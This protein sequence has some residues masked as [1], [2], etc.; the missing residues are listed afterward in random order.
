MNLSGIARVASIKFPARPSWVP[1]IPDAPKIITEIDEFR[2]GTLK[3]VL[4]LGHWIPI[5]EPDDVAMVRA[6]RQI[7]TPRQMSE[8]ERDAIDFGGAY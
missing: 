5:G 2:A 6:S 4:P 8:E 7:Y 3:S 1:T